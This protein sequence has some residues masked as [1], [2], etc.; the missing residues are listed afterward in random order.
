[1]LQTF[2]DCKMMQIEIQKILQSM[3]W[4]SR[5]NL[6]RKPSIFPR[7]MGFSC[8]FSRDFPI[9]VDPANRASFAVRCSDVSGCGGN[10][11]RTCAGG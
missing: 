11:S 8:K 7:N 5:E 9:F 4:F 3:D 6:N 1:M 2:A 10:F